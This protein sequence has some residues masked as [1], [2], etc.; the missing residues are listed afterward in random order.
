LSSGSAALNEVPGEGRRVFRER[1]SDLGW[2]VGQ[3]LTFESRYAEGNLERL[4]GLAAELVQL[5]VSMIVAF[6]T[7]PSLAAKRATATIPI[8]MFAG[9]PVGSGLIASLAH[10][11]GNITGQTMEAGLEIFS[12]RLDLLKQAASKISRVGILANRS[13]TSEARVL[14]AMAPVAQALRLTFLPVEVRTSRDF[15]DAFSVLSRERVDALTATENP[16]NVEH[17]G[18]IVSFAARNRLP[19]MFGERLFVDAGGLMSYGISFIDLLRHLPT[20]VDKIL[21]GAKPA[22]LPVEQPTTFELVIN[23][24]TARALGITVPTRC[25]CGRTT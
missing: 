24:Q 13:N 6:G 22:D 5:K 15:A 1:L 11:G 20:Y 17:R 23:L 8:V 25:C 12:K 2:I 4:P 21:R 18:A 14:D 3:N 9:D 16:L 7:Q 10:P 19:V